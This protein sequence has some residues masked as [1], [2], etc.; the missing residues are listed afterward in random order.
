MFTDL[1]LQQNTVFSEKLTTNSGD[2]LISIEVPSKGKYRIG[3]FYG[4][5]GSASP[6]V[7][8]VVSQPI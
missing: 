6:R 4:L 5:T 2:F 3:I 7:F 8:Q 1:L